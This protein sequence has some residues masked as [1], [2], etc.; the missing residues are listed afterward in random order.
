MPIVSPPSKFSQGVLRVW[1]GFSDRFENLAQTTRD[2]YVLMPAL[3]VGVIAAA[4]IWNPVGW[5]L[6]F[7]ALGLVGYKAHQA[8]SEYFLGGPRKGMYQAGETVADITLMVGGVAVGRTGQAITHVSNGSN[9][10]AALHL[11]DEVA[12]GII[13]FKNTLQN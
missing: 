13:V 8:S 7:A 1:E 6:T 10:G 5:T 2:H 11:V 4:T 9:A 12:S 3:T